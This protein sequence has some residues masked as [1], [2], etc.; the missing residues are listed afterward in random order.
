[1][2]FRDNCVLSG[3][4]RRFDFGD[5]LLMIIAWVHQGSSRKYLLIIDFWGETHLYH[6]RGL[7]NA[8][9]TLR[10]IYTFLPRHI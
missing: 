4:S 3:R 5:W 7:A 8:V 2:E 6:R 1:M 9:T 10:I